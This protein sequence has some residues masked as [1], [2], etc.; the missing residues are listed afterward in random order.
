MRR[1]PFKGIVKERLLRVVYVLHS[2]GATWLCITVIFACVSPTPT[3]ETLIFF[4]PLPYCE[5]AKYR[6][7]S[8]PMGKS[9]CGPKSF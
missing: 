6:L 3:F 4:Q 7:D 9:L 5:A 8:D 2:A 1:W